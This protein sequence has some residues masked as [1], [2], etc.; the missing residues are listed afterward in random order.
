MNDMKKTLLYTAVLMSGIGLFQSCTGDMEMPPMIAPEATWTP[1]T[2]IAALKADVWQTDRNYVTEVGQRDG[3]DVIIAGR[4]VSS[5]KAGNVFKNVVLQDETAALTIAINAYDL[6]ET[7]QPGQQIVVNLTGLKIGGYNSLLQV[8]GE[9]T[10]N[11]SPSMTFMEKELF[12]KHAQQNGLAD[13]ARV[14]TKV[15]TIPELMTAKNSVKG[16]QKWQS[17]YSPRQC[18]I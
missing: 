16:L 9:G 8:G 17:H 3:H 1:N 7:Y 2:T 15:T 14:D 10:Y 6:Y 13:M 5:D 11:G 18:H 4:V 12:A